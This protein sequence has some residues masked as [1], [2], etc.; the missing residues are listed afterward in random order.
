LFA[1]DRE[2]LERIPKPSV[3]V[4]AEVCRKREVP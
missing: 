3:A 1:V 4:Y 2:T